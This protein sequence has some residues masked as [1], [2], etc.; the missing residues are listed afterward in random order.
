[1][2]VNYA[3]KRLD[4]GFVTVLG[5]VIFER[6]LDLAMVA[7]VFGILIMTTS[8]INLPLNYDT[9]FVFGVLLCGGLVVAIVQNRRRIVSMLG[10]RFP[11]TVDNPEWLFELLSYRAIWSYLLLS[12]L[13]WSFYALRFQFVLTSI[14]QPF[15]FGL[16]ALLLVATAAGFLIPA[17][18]GA[19]GTYHM[20]VVFSMHNIYGIDLITAQAAS[21]ILHLSAYVPS[22]LL[23]LIIFLGSAENIRDASYSN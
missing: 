13:V 1:M 21:I 9:Y 19:I 4:K 8:M 6:L 7:I 23:G 18:P 2:R 5:T 16:V 15:D 10:K 11:N 17:A 22:T 12:I 20:A 3:R 14:G